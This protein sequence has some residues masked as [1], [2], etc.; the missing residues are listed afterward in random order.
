MRSALVVSEIAL[1]LVLIV[2]AGL[3]LRSFGRLMHVDPGFD[4]E[5]V[6]TIRLRLPD[7]KY[8]DSS[9]TMGFGR[10]TLRRV[11]ALPGVRHASLSTGFPLGNA[12]DNEYT[13]EGDA[14]AERG[15]SPVALTEFVSENYHQALGVGL[16]AGRYFNEQDTADSPPV[17]IVD[18][19][20]AGRHFH[21][22]PPAEVIGKRLRLGSESPWRQIV[23]VVKHV[24]H[25]GLD[26]EARAEIYRPYTQIDP[27]WLAEFTRVLD[28]VVKTKTEPSAFIAPIKGEI[29]AI[30]KDQPLAN[31]RTLS[32]LL[33]GSL[34]PRRFNML[35]LSIFAGTALVLGSVGVY[36]VMSYMVA[37]RTREIGIRLALG[38]GPRRVVNLVLRRCLVLTVTGI[39]IGVAAALALTRVMSGLLYDISPTDAATFVAAG[40]I[41]GVVAV[42]AAVVPARR[43]T[44]VDPISALRCE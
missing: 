20:F 16:V 25:S 36:G 32:A 13:V 2:G 29:Q 26:E 10:E 12:G 30:D 44:R 41:L 37:E 43:A 42:A 22:L 5:N 1:S 23:G 31:V 33:D 18:T 40:L 17:A 28:L 4:A 15:Q 24:R 6:L 8:R 14:P 38:A 9:Q 21:E 11:S 7:A 3:L 39:S 19:E 35:L 27:K 34:A